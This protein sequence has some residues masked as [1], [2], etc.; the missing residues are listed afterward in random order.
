MP[1]NQS[2]AAQQARRA[3]RDG[4]K[5]TPILRE[6]A[7]AQLARQAAEAGEEPWQRRAGMSADEQ[8]IDDCRDPR[9]A[10]SRA[11][12]LVGRV[13]TELDGG[14]YWP[15]RATEFIAALLRAAGY[16]RKPLETVTA[17]TLHPEDHEPERILADVD[18]RAAEELHRLRA[19]LATDHMSIADTVR[20]IVLGAL[21][22][23]IPPADEGATAYD[24]AKAPDLSGYDWSDPVAYE[25]LLSDHPWAVWERQRQERDGGPAAG[26][27]R[28]LRT[29]WMIRRMEV[30]SDYEYP[31]SH[32]NA[33]PPMPKLRTAAK[34][35]Q[36]RLIGETVYGPHYEHD[37]CSWI[38]CDLEDPGVKWACRDQRTC[39]HCGPSSTAWPRI[40]DEWKTW[41]RG[42]Y[43]VCESAALRQL[44]GIPENVIQ[45]AELIEENHQTVRPCGSDNARDL[46]I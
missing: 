7:D 40:K 27:V 16:G 15:A 14:T 39:P 3:A 43:G 10:Q 26:D 20:A 5:Y 46:R 6:R 13:W 37:D 9:A 22:R 11:R 23:G 17:W 1:K 28:M 21:G 31:E 32:R 41:A 36:A 35:A 24:Q 2:T 42:R 19:Q 38:E 4:A 45:T 29:A 34:T 8:W 25:W 33:Y 18:E 44:D 12:T 30:D